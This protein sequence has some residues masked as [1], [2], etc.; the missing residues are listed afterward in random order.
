MTTTGMPSAPPT[1]Y[2]TRRDSMGRLV[3]ATW[4]SAGASP[5][6]TGR[7]HWLVAVDG[8]ACALRAAAMAA[9]LA[10]LKPNAEVDLVHVE[11]WLSK[12]AAEA[13]LMQRSWTATAPARQLLE[14]AA[15]HW[16]LHALMGGDAAMEIVGLA[17][18][19]GSCG[20]AIGSQGLTAAE[21]LFMGSVAYKMFHLAKTPVLVVAPHA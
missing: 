6:G 10:A 1:P 21:S 19:L 20:L 16:H 15:L 14:A 18:A 12:E 11:P 13:E 7:A 2:L 17:H 9:R 8:S 3:A 4:H 5:A